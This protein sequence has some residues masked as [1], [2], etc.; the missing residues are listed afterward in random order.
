MSD[1]LQQSNQ[2]LLLRMVVVVVAM[3]GFGFAM[4]PI[5]NVI[6]D[7][8]GLNG[9]TGVLNAADVDGKVDVSRTVTVEFIANLNETMPWEFRP[10]VTRME[11]HPGAVNTTSYYARNKTDHVMVG[12]AIPSVMPGKAAQHFNKT[13]CF[14][15]TQQRFEA[16]QEMDMPV[17]FVVDRDL[18][19][20]IKVM[21]LSYT[22]FDITD[23]AGSNEPHKIASVKTNN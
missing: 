4:V 1:N 12:Q 17:R 20:D 23:R 18:P 2:R 7:I 3:F 16:G 6:C 13:E 14:C 22:F 21:T 10:T 11:V 15:F 5:Y 8:T 9:K 19:A